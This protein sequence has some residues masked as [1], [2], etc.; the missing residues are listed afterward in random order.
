MSRSAPRRAARAGSGTAPRRPRCVRGDEPLP[1]RLAAAVAPQAL[2]TTARARR[3]LPLAQPPLL[4]RLGSRLRVADRRLPAG[5]LPPSAPPLA[6]RTGRPPRRSPA[7]CAGGT[8]PGHPGQAAGACARCRSTASGGPGAC[9]RTTAARSP[10]RSP[11]GWRARRL[12]SALTPPVTL[13]QRWAA[14]A[15]APVRPR[16]PVRRC[17]RPA[18][19][20]SRPTGSAGSP[21]PVAA[22]CTSR[23]RA[24][25]PIA[26]MPRSR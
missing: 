24:G 18:A 20:R 23:A 17:G 4:L 15:C 1:A 19:G 22:C 5:P 13:R 3:P 7:G 25:R 6:R 9:S 21:S 11:L 8:R 2:S 10:S 26:P 14:V 12:P 16:G